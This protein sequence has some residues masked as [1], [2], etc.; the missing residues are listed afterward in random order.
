MI[1]KNFR[2]MMTFLSDGG[3]NMKH[4]LKI[5]PEWYEA[6]LSGLK[7][8]EIRKDDRNPKFAPGDELFLREFDGTKY[9][10]RT[11]TAKVKLVL[12][13]E[14]CK[15]GYCIMSVDVVGYYSPTTKRK[16]F[17]KLKAMSIEEMAEFLQMVWEQRADIFPSRCNEN[18][19]C[20]G[21]CTD[22]PSC[23]HQWLLESEGEEDV[24]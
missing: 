4:D 7:P 18:S 17:D 8:F 3:V 16:H 23:I 9:T 13:N 12:R 11:I 22:T 19:Y 10:G 15:E 21:D 5:L 14:Y 2:L 20:Y 1:L 24:P 6:L